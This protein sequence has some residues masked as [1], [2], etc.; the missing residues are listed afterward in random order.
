MEDVGWNG[1]N[2][3]RTFTSLTPAEHVR[4]AEALTV[5]ATAMADV[6]RTAYARGRDAA[7]ASN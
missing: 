4:L 5:A 6:L 2:A 1:D 3:H 7:G